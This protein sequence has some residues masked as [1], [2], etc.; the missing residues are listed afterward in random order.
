MNEEQ[1]D[2]IE[3]NLIG[4]VDSNRGKKTA[5]HG[6]FSYLERIDKLL[7]A[8]DFLRIPQPQ[9][10]KTI[11]GLSLI[12]H[13]QRI[14]VLNS[15]F[16]ELYPKMGQDAKTQHLEY[17]VKLDSEFNRTKKEFQSNTHKITVLFSKMSDFW[18]LELRDFC[19]ERGLLMPSS[20]DGLDA[21]NQ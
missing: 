19:E 14:G 10:A 20:K 18:E 3:S 6:G 1:V 2:N 4:A 12:D 15:L 8:L 5:F 16:Q 7:R 17:K 9:D 13:A 11:M 21:A